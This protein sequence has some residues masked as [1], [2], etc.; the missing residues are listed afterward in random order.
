MHMTESELDTV[1]SD[2]E[3][4]IEDIVAVAEKFAEEEIWRDGFFSFGGG[5]N[6][7]CGKRIGEKVVYAVQNAVD[8]NLNIYDCQSKF[9][10]MSGEVAPLLSVIEEAKR[11]LQ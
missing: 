7:A 9:D 3:R 5:W 1:L 2:T 11:E 10:K 8:N 4:A 6:D